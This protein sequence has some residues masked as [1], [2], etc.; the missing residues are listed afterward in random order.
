LQWGDKDVKGEFTF[1]A[2][3][4][5]IVRKKDQVHGYSFK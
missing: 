3:D 5:L 4:L 1:V 2:D